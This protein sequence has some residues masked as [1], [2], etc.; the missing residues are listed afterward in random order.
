MGRSTRRVL[1]PALAVRAL[2]GIVAVAATGSITGGSNRTRQPPDV[3]FDTIFS[4]VALALVPAAIL[5]VYGLAQR[6][7]VAEEYAKRK[8]RLS[9]GTLILLLLLFPVLVYLRGVP[10]L[11]PPPTAQPP[12]V[13]GHPGT[14]VTPPGNANATQYEPRFAWLPVTVI[15]AL[16]AAAVLAWYVSSRRRTRPEREEVLTETLANVLEDTL[17]DLRAEADPRR[18]VIAAYARLE[19]ALATQGLGRRAAE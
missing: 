6:R 17:D 7:D 11:R 1:V 4:L 2:V 18:A 5:L 19:R 10:K 14:P 16:L 8:R 13:P 12:I 3:L 15:L 9:N